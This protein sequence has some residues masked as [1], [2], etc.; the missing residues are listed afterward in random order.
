MKGK[1]LQASRLLEPGLR[2]RSSGAFMSGEALAEQPNDEPWTYTTA[3]ISDILG[4][5]D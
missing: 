4:K 2:G 1:H 5:I 3:I